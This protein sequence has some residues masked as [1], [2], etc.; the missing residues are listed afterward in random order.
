[1]SAPARKTGP[2]DGALRGEILGSTLPEVFADLQARRATGTLV[3][4][5][6]SVRRTAQ[7]RDGRIQFAASTD[8]D[9]RFNQ[10][11]VKAGVIKLKDLLRAIEVALATRDRLGEV[12]VKMKMVEPADVEKWVRAQVRGILFNMI[13]QASGQ[14]SFEPGP[15]PAEAIPLELPAAHA[16]F[17]GVR[18][19]SSW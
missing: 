12:L 10:V 13:E 7:L 18:K 15:V 16:A 9:D 17:E 19:F 14:W 2:A 4:V 6:G 11:L 8:R 5:T 1:M 3:A